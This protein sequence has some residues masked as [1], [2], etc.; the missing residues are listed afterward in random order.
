MPKSSRHPRATNGL[1]RPN[2]ISIAKADGDADPRSDADNNLI[3]SCDAVYNTTNSWYNPAN[4]PPTCPTAATTGVAVY[5]WCNAASS[6]AAADANEPFGYLTG[7]YTPTGYRYTFG[8]GSGTDV[9]NDG[10]PIS[11]VGATYQQVDGTMRTPTAA[12]TYDP[13]GNVTSVNRGN[14]TWTMTYDGLNR[15]LSSVDPD[16][17]NPTSYTYYNSDGS[18]SK[19]ETP[20]QHANG[21]GNTFTYDADGNAVSTAAYREK[22][23][24]SSPIQDTTNYWY[25]GEDR[26][27]EVQQAL[28]PAND[29]YVNPWTTRYLYELSQNNTSGSTPGFNGMASFSAH[30]NL[31]KTQEFLPPTNPLAMASPAPHGVANTTFLD[32]QGNAFDTLDRPTARYSLIAQTQASAESLVE[33]TLTYDTSSYFGGD[34]AGEL[35]EDCNSASPQ[36]CSW[37]NYDARGAAIQ[38]H[39][40]DISSPDRS[41]TYDPDGSTASLTSA[42]FGT[43]TYTYDANEHEATKQEVSGGGVTSPAEFTHE[44]YQDGTLKQLDV[45]SSAL[46]Q[47]GLFAYSYRPDG[48]IQT[49]AI[50]DTAQANVGTTSDAYTY[51]AAGRPTQRSEAGPG[52]LSAPSSWQYD[53]YGRLN[54]INFPFCSACGGSAAAQL[55]SL[56]WDPQGQLMGTASQT[57]NYT[58][59]GELLNAQTLMANSVSVASG[60]AQSLDT[61]AGVIVS[62]TYDPAGRLSTMGALLTRTY[63]AENHTIQTSTQFGSLVTGTPATE[64]GALGVNQ[65]GPS[66]HPVQIGSAINASRTVPS[67]S[68]VAYD[69]LHWDGDQLIFT[70]NASGQVDDIKVGASGDITPLDQTFTGLTFYDRGPDGS[71]M[72][73]HNATGIQLWLTL[74]PYPGTEQ[75][76]GGAFANGNGH[77][78]YFQSSILWNPQK[79]TGGPL[80]LYFFFQVGVGQGKVLGMPRTDGI[81]D[82]FSAIQGVRTYDAASGQWTTP[83]AFAGTT[84]N[85]ASQKSYLWNGGNPLRNSDPTGFLCM[86]ADSCG[87]AGEPTPE[88]PVPDLNDVLLTPPIVN[89]WAPKIT[90]GAAVA[91]AKPKLHGCPPATT[92]GLRPPGNHTWTEAYDFGVWLLNQLED[93]ADPMAVALTYKNAT[94]PTNAPFNYQFQEGGTRYEGNFNL[95]VIAAGAD[96]SPEMNDKAIAYV[97]S[98]NGLNAFQIGQDEK[99]NHRGYEWATQNCNP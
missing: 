39:F 9:A 74:A 52:A 42:V 89:V 80:G 84:D 58:V 88:D 90:F 75:C 97:G 10:L 37:Y 27:V 6:C 56:T 64:D 4:P 32:I 12:F 19:T 51:S 8:Y 82:G 95:G 61:Q 62:G 44:Y 16:P 63:D 50:S 7:A 87:Y 5:Q 36:Q 71:V 83:D 79:Q 57:F 78:M 69:T 99:A 24:T 23:S 65:W 96:F 60:S 77:T 93:G 53:S 72:G 70:T 91:Q 11:V 28:D 43:E 98:G 18:I 34:L 45:A 49:L 47:T 2:A 3:S 94:V 73:C 15:Q 68:S 59:R 20:Y 46:T 30:G 54:Q 81:V 67:A 29:L 21:W 17:G 22:T 40:N 26:L 48:R 25:D 86:P 31:F 41:A 76:S 66:G 13:Y 1:P 33:E 92:N 85:P 55:T 38:V 14:G 35:T